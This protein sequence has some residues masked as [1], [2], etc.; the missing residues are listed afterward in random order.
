MFTLSISRGKDK[1]PSGKTVSD[2]KVN[3]YNTVNIG[4]QILMAENLK[5]TK[6]PDGTKIDNTTDNAVWNYLITPSYCWYKND[7]SYKNIYGSYYNWHAVNP[8]NLCPTGWHVPS[9][10]EWITLTNYLGSE[11]V[12]GDKPKEA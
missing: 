2:I 5:T 7:N 8:Q 9:D 12:A 3:V 10:D 1:Y 6:F 11:S 4:T